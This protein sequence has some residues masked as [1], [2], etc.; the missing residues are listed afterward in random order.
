VSLPEHSIAGLS[1]RERVSRLEHVCNSS[2]FVFLFHSIITAVILGQL[3]LLGFAMGSSQAYLLIKFVELH[4]VN[5]QGLSIF[6]T[7]PGDT[8]HLAWSC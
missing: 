3:G 7:L 5:A 6:Q 4:R 1:V 8:S 2:G